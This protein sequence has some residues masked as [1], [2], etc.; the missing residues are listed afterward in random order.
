MAATFEADLTRSLSFRKQQ[1]RQFVKLCD[2]QM[3][4]LLEAVQKDIGK[5]PYETT[6]CELGLIRDDAMRALD[7]LS[8]WA[9]PEY[10]NVRFAFLLSRPHVRKVPFGMVLI[11]GAW[12]YPLVL[13]LA[14]F[15]GAIAAGNT[16]ILKVSLFCM[17]L[18]N[19]YMQ[20]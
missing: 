13:L 11:M 6:M 19:L 8:S 10:P 7:K 12:N 17:N 1:L 5:H 9:K 14:P 15:I 2:E 16:V 20:Y 18:V 4:V 3:D